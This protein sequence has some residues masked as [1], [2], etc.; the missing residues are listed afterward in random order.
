[1]NNDEFNWIVYNK[2]D[3]DV[4]V[5]IDAYDNRIWRCVCPLICFEIVEMHCPNR[6]MRQFKMCQSVP[7]QLLVDCDDLHNIS[8]IGHRNTD[9]REYHQNSIN[10]WN[11][12]LN[13]VARGD[14]HGR[15]NQQT[16]DDYFPWFE[17]ITVRIISPI[18]SGL[19]FRPYPPNIDVGGQNNIPQ[20]FSTPSPDSHQSSFG[21]VP[22]RPHGGFYGAGPSGGLYNTG[23]S[24]GFENTGQ[25]GGLYTTGSSSGLYNTGP[26]VGL[27]SAGPSGSYVDAGYQTP[28]WENIHNFTD[29]LNSNWQ[30]PGQRNTLAPERNVVSPVIFSGY[31]DEQQERSEEIVDVPVVRRG[32]RRH[33]PP[34]CGSGGHLYN[35]NC[36]EQS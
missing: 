17:C 35:C 10:S 32:Q 29:L 25:S 28:F 5:L 4:K 34:A 8:R 11:N 14:L 2:K 33:R 24:G 9:W 21:F 19:G 15:S 18:V 23:P 3:P 27:Y 1:M 22:P 12:K 26:S 31:S 13:H 7:R 20:N 36:H 30:Q 16:D 6:V